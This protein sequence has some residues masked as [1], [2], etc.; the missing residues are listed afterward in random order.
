MNLS[1]YRT[2]LLLGLPMVIGQIGVIILG[3]A[4][5]LMIGHHSATELA[6][7][8]FVNNMFNL[9]II[10]STG[11]AYGL[12]PVVGSL[13]GRNQ[14]KEAGGMLKNSLVA[15]TVLALLVCAVMTLL[16]MRP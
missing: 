14:L 4:D 3:L 8:S 9:A 7:A 15:N 6:A 12:T 13:F 16:Y 11:F 5:T 10:F 2:L 1:H